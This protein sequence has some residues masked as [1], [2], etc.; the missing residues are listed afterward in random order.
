V[1]SVAGH[2]RLTAD[3]EHKVVDDGDGG[4]VSAVARLTEAG[5]RAEAGRPHRR[6]EHVGTQRVVEVAGAE[7]H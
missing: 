2:R 5:E 3:D 1:A 6:R 7:D 4:E